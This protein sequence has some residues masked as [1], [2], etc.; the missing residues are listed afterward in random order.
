MV[1]LSLPA[2]K[3][4]IFNAG[5]T[6]GREE[7][8]ISNIEKSA[9]RYKECL[10]T[11]FVSSKFVFRYDHS[12]QGELSDREWFNVIKLQNGVECSRDQVG[13][14][15]IKTISVVLICWDIS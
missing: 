8:L 1:K 9:Q 14:F 13:Q 7:E 4:I 3:Q 12:G 15:I 11:T 6:G 2:V 5:L 10:K